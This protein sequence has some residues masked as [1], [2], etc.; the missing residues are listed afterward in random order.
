MKPEMA[1]LRSISERWAVTA[2]LLRA[3]RS[4]TS[5]TTSISDSGVPGSCSRGMSANRLSARMSIIHFG[6]VAKYSE[7]TRQAGPAR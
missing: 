4:D 2:A 7:R 3:A 6:M 1:R 5:T